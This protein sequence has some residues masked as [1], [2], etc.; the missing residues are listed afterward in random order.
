MYLYQEYHKIAIIL[1][2]STSDAK[3]RH[4]KTGLVWPTK[5]FYPA[6]NGSLG[7]TRPKSKGQPGQPGTGHTCVAGRGVA[8]KLDSASQQPPQEQ[9]L[10]VAVASVSAAANPGT[11]TWGL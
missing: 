1:V 6:S 7:P 3:D 8:Q 4:S 9:L 2:T 5:G 11:A 10:Q